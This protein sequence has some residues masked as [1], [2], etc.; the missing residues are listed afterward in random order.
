MQSDSLE[1]SILNGWDNDDD[2]YLLVK[3][4]FKVKV[5]FN[6]EVFESKFLGISNKSFKIHEFL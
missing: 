5:K 3:S 4:I 6:L 2:L 1:K